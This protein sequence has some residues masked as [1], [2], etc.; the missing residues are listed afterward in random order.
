M[1]FLLK[2]Y[3]TSVLSLENSSI[4]K[5]DTF[6]KITDHLPFL[7]VKAI[8]GRNILNDYRLEKT[9]EA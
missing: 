3:L 6:Y 4:P 9:K 5:R 7:N 8:K 1:I 2:I